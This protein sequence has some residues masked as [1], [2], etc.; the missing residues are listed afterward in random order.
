VTG[1]APEELYGRSGYMFTNLE[2]VWICN[3]YTV[4]T[5]ADVR[6]RSA[7]P[8]KTL[9]RHGCRFELLGAHCAV[10]NTS[11]RSVRGTRVERN[12]RVE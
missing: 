9:T 10:S 8:V 4:A 1:V 5:S 2:Y 3:V 11:S 6:R 12:A 7:V